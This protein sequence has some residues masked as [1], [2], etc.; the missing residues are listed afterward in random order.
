LAFQRVCHID[1][2][3]EGCG[4]CV[5]VGEI[6]IGLYRV[7]DAIHAMENRCPHQG[8]PLHQGELKGAIIVCEAHGW[9][10][11]VR[12]GFNPIDDDGWPIP[13]FAV[14]LE[15]E[16]VSIDIEQVINLPGRRRS[17]RG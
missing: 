6:A 11:D 10:F 13:C 15:G 2:I 17:T 8:Y 7:A 14:M 3:P 9:E 5:R 4:H 1:E 12:T 16:E